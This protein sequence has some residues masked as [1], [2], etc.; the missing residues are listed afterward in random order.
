M[1]LAL[2][3]ILLVAAI[4]LTAFMLRSIK[5]SKMSIEDG[6]YW[7]AFALVILLMGVFPIIPS[8]LSQLLG[9]QSPVNFVFLF[10][11]FILIIR[12]F[13]SN[14][15]ISQLEDKVKEL[16]QRIALE[17]FDHYERRHL[18]DDAKDE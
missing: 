5:K 8:S 16:T 2:R 14:R 11:I 1:S 6:M 18:E 3:I 13:S 12:D 9:F 10:F 7:I 17:R 15:R 4:G